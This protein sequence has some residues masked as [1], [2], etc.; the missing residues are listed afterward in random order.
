MPQYKGQ[1]EK[2]DWYEFDASDSSEATP[3]A[4]GYERV[5]EIATG[6]EITN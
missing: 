3:E 5:V 2:G 1:D 4:T 6:R